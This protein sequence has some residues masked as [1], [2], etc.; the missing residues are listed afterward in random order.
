MKK[1]VNGVR[2]RRLFL[3]KS[4]KPLSS[5]VSFMPML[6]CFHFWMNY[7]NKAK[8]VVNVLLD[9]KSLVTK[10]KLTSIQWITQLVFPI[11]TT[12]RYRTKILKKERKKQTKKKTNGRPKSDLE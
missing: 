4:V 9:I 5:A 2:R 7:Y 11:L 6:I 10:K 12:S 3:D 1:A 8:T